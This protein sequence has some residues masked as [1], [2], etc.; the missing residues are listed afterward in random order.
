MPRVTGRSSHARIRDSHV[1]L[2]RRD[3]LR[4]GAVGVGVSLS[5]WLGRA[6]RRRGADPQRKRSCILLWMN[7]GP[8]QM[9]TFDLKPGH[10][11]GG[12]FKADR[13]RR[14]R[15]PDQR[16]PA[17]G[18]ASSMKHLAIVRS[19]TTKEGDHGRATLPAPHRLPSRRG[20]SSTRRSARSCRRNSAPTTP[21]CRTSSASPRSASSARRRTGPASSARS[22]PRSIVGEGGVRRRSSRATVDRALRVQ[23]LGPAGGRRPRRRPTPGSTCSRELQ[24][25]FAGRPPRRRRPRATRRAY[26]RAVRLMRSAAAKAFD[27][28]DEKPATLRDAYGRNLFGQG[29]LLARRLVERGVPFVEVTLGGPAASAGTRTPT[30]STR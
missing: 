10:A 5:G 23:D 30:T 25:D 6:G 20:R 27:L 29:C 14:P 3:F 19:M 8:S 26:D 17:A 7:G 4:V 15:H 18:R 21:R 13:H 12:P 24:R 16:A 9:D 28:D 22:T 11:N 2:D 1:S